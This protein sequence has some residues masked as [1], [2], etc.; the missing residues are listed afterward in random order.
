MIHLYTSAGL[1]PP[2]SFESLTKPEIVDAIIAARE[3]DDDAVELPPS[4]PR[5]ESEYSSEGDVDDGN[6][7]GGEETDVASKPGRTRNITNPLRR[8]A[9]VNDLMRGAAK[10]MKGRSLSM[11]QLGIGEN[12]KSGRKGAGDGR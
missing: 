5:G 8:R 4:S 6:I 12:P 11:G 9:T 7:A 10:P 1:T 2:S 3:D